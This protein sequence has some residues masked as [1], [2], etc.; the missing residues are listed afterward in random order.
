MC[1]A[2]CQVYKA[3][4]E[5]RQS[6]AL[7]DTL[8]SDPRVIKISMETFSFPKIIK[9]TAGNNRNTQKDRNKSLCLLFF[10]ACSN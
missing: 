3:A 5:R 1:R 8:T 7:K 2:R 4:D 6:F 9:I 10:S